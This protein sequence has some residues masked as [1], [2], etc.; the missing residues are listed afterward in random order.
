MTIKLSRRLTHLGRYPEET[1][2]L[3]GEGHRGW[4]RIVGGGDW[5]G[6]GSEWDVK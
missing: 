2:M 6:R 3:R 4:G 1:H 5:E